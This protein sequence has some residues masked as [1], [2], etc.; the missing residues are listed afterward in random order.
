MCSG[1]I[2]FRLLIPSKSPQLGVGVG[3][4]RG[5]PREFLFLSG[6]LWLQPLWGSN[7]SSPLL[8]VHSTYLKVPSNPQQPERCFKNKMARMPLN[9]VKYLK[10]PSKPLK[11][12]LTQLSKNEVANLWQKTN[13]IRG[14]KFWHPGN[15]VNLSSDFGVFHPIRFRPC[16]RTDLAPL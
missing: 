15:I 7:V 8:P 10:T 9:T 2:D 11:T 3:S 14:Q 16:A 1:S 12:Q 5:R 4:W 6:V 13:H